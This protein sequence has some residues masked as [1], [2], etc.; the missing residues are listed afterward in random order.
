MVVSIWWQILIV[1]ILLLLGCV[2][3]NFRYKFKINGYIL[4]YL[5]FI[6]FYT[7]SAHNFTLYLFLK[8]II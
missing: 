6:L 5:L 4:M 7:T 3:N 8:N 1:I 2:N